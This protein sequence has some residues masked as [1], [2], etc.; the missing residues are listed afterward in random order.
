MEIGPRHLTNSKRPVKTIEDLKGLKVRIQP[1]EP[2]LAMFRALGANPV[3]IAPG[4]DQPE[5]HPVRAGHPVVPEQ[6]CLAV[7]R[8][9]RD[10]EVAV[11]VEVAEREPAPGRRHRER[12]ARL[13]RHVP[14][15]AP[16][17][18][19]ERERRLLCFLKY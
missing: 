12:A 16:A 1:L 7:E 17:V 18:V 19:P 6:V 10:V 13:R 2:H 15:L 14:E 11:V 4:A 5:R 9:D 8:A 3:A